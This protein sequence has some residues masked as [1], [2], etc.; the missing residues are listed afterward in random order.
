MASNSANRSSGFLAFHINNLATARGFRH[1]RPALKG[2]SKVRVNAVPE[3]V[4]G[5]TNGPGRAVLIVDPSPDHQ[6]RL[7]RLMAVHGH[8][9]IG[10]SSLD[11]AFAFLQAFPADLVLLAEEAAGATPRS[12]VA[13][14]ADRRPNARVAIM[15]PNDHVELEGD[16][17][18][19]VPPLDKPSVDAD[20]EPLT[21]LE[22]VPHAMSG[23]TLAA[24]LPS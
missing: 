3:A 18:G 1:A 20:G 6:A 11:G 16:G 14:I 7:A 23:E 9:A 10:T 15:V 12:V 22:Y 2:V 13:D 21:A 8:R 24:L 17:D 4:K 19:S 5:L